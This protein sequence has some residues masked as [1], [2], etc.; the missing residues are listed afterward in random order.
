MGQHTSSP[1]ANRRANETFDKNDY[2]KAAMTDLSKMREQAERALV[3]TRSPSETRIHIHEHK[4][5]CRANPHEDYTF[6]FGREE[7][8]A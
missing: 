3:D 2:H 6:V 1:M 4:V 8:N 7:W 5:P